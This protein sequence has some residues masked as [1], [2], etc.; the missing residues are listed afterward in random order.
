MGR[1]RIGWK[2][3]DVRAAWS[4]RRTRNSRSARSRGGPARSRG[5]SPSARGAAHDGPRRPPGGA[6]GRAGGETLF[7]ACGDFYRVA[8]TAKT[9]ETVWGWTHDPTHA[10]EALAAVRGGARRRCRR[11]PAS[12]L[13]RDR[14]RARLALRPQDHR[15][16]QL[17]GGTLY[18]RVAVKTG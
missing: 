3:S 8:V 17:P 12:A 15:R 4:R 10:V 2:N 7:L 9:L 13:R 16:R 5:F 11:G 1:W 6:G 18:D 14:H